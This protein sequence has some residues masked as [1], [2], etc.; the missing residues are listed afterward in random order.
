MD[1]VRALGPKIENIAWHKAGIF[2]TG[3]PAF[4][5]EQ[6]PEVGVVLRDLATE[7]SVQL[8]SVDIVDRLPPDMRVLR[9]KVQKMN[10]SLAISFAETVLKKSFLEPDFRLSE[11]DIRKGS[12]NFAWPGRFHYYQD[13]KCQWYPDTA[14]NELS[15]KVATEWFAQSA[16]TLQQRYYITITL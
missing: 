4:T 6:S 15:L 3:V 14:H 2:K 11:I 8:N 7:K 12:D 5:M 9:F 13:G 16:A 1:H 10:A